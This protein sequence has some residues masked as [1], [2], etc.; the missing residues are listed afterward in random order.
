MHPIPVERAKATRNAVVIRTCFWARARKLPE[1][2]RSLPRRVSLKHLDARLSW[3]S[4]MVR[5]AMR[6]GKQWKRS[7]Y[8]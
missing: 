5:W 7:S 8:R 2:C 1:L 4:G 3:R 6:S